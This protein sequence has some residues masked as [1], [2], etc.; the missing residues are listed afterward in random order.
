LADPAAVIAYGNARFT[1]L[2]DKVIR[3][4]YSNQGKFEDRATVAFVNRRLPVPTFSQNTVAGVLSIKTASLE[5]KYQIGQPFTRTSLTI[6]S[7]NSSLG[8][9]SWY[10]G[11]PNPGNLL[12]TI[13]SL[14][15][16]N[17]QNLNCDQNKN[18]IVHDEQLH[19]EWGLIS[20]DGWVVV[21]DTSNYGLDNTFWWGSPNSDTEDLYFFGHGMNYK[22]ALTDYTKIG[23]KIAMVPRYVSGILWSRWYNVDNIDVTHVVEE[24]LTRYFPLDVYILDMDWHIKNSW[25]AYSWDTRLFP[26]PQNTLSW[27]QYKGLAV[28]ANLH[29]A[30]GVHPYEAQYVP[31]ATAMGLNPNNGQVIPFSS[32]NST[33]LRNLDDIVLRAVNNQGMDFWWI[34]WQQGG[35]AGGCT[36]SKQN[37]TYILNHLRGT[38]HIRR[39]DNIRDLVLARWGGLGT[40]R[41]QVGFSGDVAA[42]TWSNLAYQPYFSFTSSN[43]AYG[44]WSHDLV[45][46][47]TDHELHTRWLQWGAYSAIFRT[48]DRGMSAGAC[49]NTPEG[50]PIVEVWKVP[51]PYYSANRAAM[52]ERESLIPYIYGAVRQAYDTGVSILRPMYYEYPQFNNAY[53]G[54]AA[55][56]FGQYFFGDD[57]FVSPVTSQAATNTSMAKA[58][59]WIPPGTWIEKDTG[60]LVNGSADGSTVLTKSFDL[61]EIPVF[62]RAG[63]I[64][65]KI[66]VNP[67][68]TIGLARRQYTTLVIQV[69][70]GKPQN[71]INLYEDDGFSTDYVNGKST[72]TTISYTRTSTNFLL[73][74]SPPAGTYSGYPNLRNYVI[75]I[76]NGLPLVSG[77][78]NGV[79][80]SYSRNGGPNTWSYDAAR[81]TT[82]ILTSQ[83]STSTA[84]AI[85]FTTVAINDNALSGIRGILQKSILSKRNLD[86]DWTTPGSGATTGGILS[87]V[88]SSAFELSYLAGTDLPTFNKVLTG[89]PQLFT[90]AIA[91]IQSIK[92]AP[93]GALIQLWDSDRQDNVLCGSPDC[94]NDNSEYQFI[95]IEGY[96]PKAGTPGT[97][98]L[99]DFWNQNI[100]DNYATTQSSTPN[101]YTLAAFSDG[102]VYATAQPGTVPLT[103]WWND[104]RQDMLTVATADGLA[105]AKQYGYKQVNATLGHVLTSPPANV[106]EDPLYAANLARWG[107]SIELLHNALN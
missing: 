37:P 68:D 14:D 26:Y 51:D 76:V 20:R 105:Y 63:A 87:Q 22:Q 70:P 48:H 15:E 79:N 69:Y 65:P 62:V 7:V 72:L 71:S 95:R 85:S 86:F 43:V 46:P 18:V 11:Q 45:G 53:K 50:C 24:Y 58:S 82:V 55:G 36:G 67:G 21:N 100:N 1:V 6:N 17:A 25:G 41:Y 47:A 97:V 102:V 106:E 104:Q 66:P 31:M 57:M 35:T 78:V 32:V 29:D 74:V 84:A 2:T 98:S 61:S 5:L 64:I 34:D 10:Y 89:L 44:F 73:R 80:L 94:L 12:G 90:Q 40:H 99:N 27:L 54:D 39:G 101:G 42:V 33:Y 3:I 92:P 103:L 59:I 56:N 83:I 28:A 96:Q 16:V 13:K 30:D 49:S 23:G 91:E 19:C 9:T 38:D 4:E 88:A 107:Y 52:I 93:A 60:V 75:E 77:T 8:W 81:A